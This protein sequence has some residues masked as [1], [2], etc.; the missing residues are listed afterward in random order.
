MRAFVLGLVVLLVAAAGPAAAGEGKA[1]LTCAG[2]MGTIYGTAA[3]E[4]IVGTAGNDVIIAEGGNDTVYGYGGNDV[5]CGMKGDDTVYGGAGD[6]EV[7]GGTGNDLI[8]GGPGADYLHAGKGADTLFGGADN[9]VLDSG[10]GSGKT[11]S[12]NDGK[13]RLRIRDASATWIIGRGGPGKDQVDFRWAPDRVTVRLDVTAS[14]P[15]FCFGSCSG[16]NGWLYDVENVMGTRYDDVIYGNAKKNLLKGNLGDDV[17]HGMAGDDRIDG[18]AG[19]DTLHGRLGD[20]W[21]DGGAG[22]NDTGDGG[23]DSNTGGVDQD[24]CY[25]IEHPANCSIVY[26]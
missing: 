1:N 13:D 5:I 10:I 2:H 14:D 21:L 15:Y 4:V 25:L 24:S 18:C 19:N 6:D 23:A 26:S 17:I 12:G 7:Y 20:D 8:Y 22:A 11:L 3:G 9:D 16:H